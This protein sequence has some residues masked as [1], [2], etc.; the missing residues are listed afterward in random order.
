[1]SSSADSSTSTKSDD[2]ERVIRS[3][4]NRMVMAEEYIVPMRLVARHMPF[5]DSLRILNISAA[6]A[7]LDV[8]ASNPLSYLPSHRVEYVEGEID[9]VFATS[10]DKP[11]LATDS[12]WVHVPDGSVDVVVSIAGLHHFSHDERAQLYAQCHR[13]LRPNGGLLVL[14]DVGVGSAQ[15]AFLNGFVDAHTPTGHRGIFFERDGA[16]LC[17]LK[18]RFGEVHVTQESYHWNFDSQEHRT[19]FCHRLFRLQCTQQETREAIDRIFG[20]SESPSPHLPW[21]LVYFV[22]VREGNPVDWLARR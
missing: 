3:A 17:E 16:D 21:N 1:M 12:R 5:R 7:E 2:Y 19:R 8:H 10:F 9:E 13:V 11:F 14:G 4:E 22:A 15:A 6:G 18:R 20:T